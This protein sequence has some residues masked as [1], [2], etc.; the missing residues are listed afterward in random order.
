MSSRKDRSDFEN[1]PYRWIFAGLIQIKLGLKYI[2]SAA[3]V[4]LL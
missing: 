4:D 2:N 3:K 1:H